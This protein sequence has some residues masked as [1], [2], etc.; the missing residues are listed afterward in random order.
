MNK[1][2]VYLHSYEVIYPPHSKLQSELVDWTLKSHLRFESLNSQ[3]EDPDKFVSHLK[4]FTLNEKQ[5]SQRYFEC[6]DVDED[7]ERHQI[8]SLSQLTPKG[9][10]IE[11]K[12]HFYAER[13]A[14]VFNQMYPAGVT[15]PKHLIHVTCTGYV[16]P[17]A[18]QAHFSSYPKAPA[19]TH[20]YHMGCYASLPAVRIAHAFVKS[21]ESSEVDIVHTEICSLHLTPTVHTPEQMVV[22]TLFAD[23]HIKYQ[24][25]TEAQGFKIILIKEKLIPDSLADM[26]WIP[27]AHGMKMTL[28]REVPF[29]IRDHLSTFLRELCE[30]AGESLENILREAIF[31]VH[32]GGP[33]IIE[34]V[35]KKL[36]LKDEQVQL[37]QKIL[38]ERGNMSSATLPHVWKEI[39]D[40]HPIPGRR[41]V[42]LAFGPGLTIFGGLFEVVG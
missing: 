5:I 38:F 36:E 30:E 25:S 40:T 21:N 1:Q 14:T 31:A 16:S 22:Q 35:Q 32:P 13:V 12:N 4:R 11:A 29:K 24:V 15:T 20:A 37:S 9:A 23:G 10:D 33:K 27:S 42:S 41:V 7:W 39:L 6:A 19:I 2:N 26:T 18:P 3:V 34:A 17:S 28:S 8:Y